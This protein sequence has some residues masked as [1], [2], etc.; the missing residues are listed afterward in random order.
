MEVV[1]S[2]GLTWSEIYRTLGVCSLTLVVATL[3]DVPVVATVDPLVW[4]TL[5]LVTFVV[6]TTSQLWANRWYYLRTLRE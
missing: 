6:A 1:T 3:A 4:A 2:H 5:S